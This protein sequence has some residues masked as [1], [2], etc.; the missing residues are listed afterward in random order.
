MYQIKNITMTNE[1]IV[2]EYLQRV[3][4]NTKWENK[5][6]AVGGC[7]RDE[8]MKIKPKDLDFVVLGDLNA[9]IEFATWLGE[10]LHIY[11]NDSNPVIYPRYGTAKLS[12]S[13]SKL[14]DIEL[15]FVAPRIEKYIENS[16]NPI[17]VKGELIDDIMRR[18]FCINSLAKNISTNEILDLSGNG[19]NDIKNC[20]IRTTS[21]P[22]IIFKDDPLRMMRAIR[23]TAKY[24]FSMLPEVV[25]SI[26]EH[27]ELINIIS[28]ERISDELSKILI[29][30]NP[31]LG[32][33]LLRKTNLLVHILG[34]EF[35]QLIGMTQNKFHVD[36]VYN[37]TLKVLSQTPPKL[38]VRLMALLHDV[39]KSE[40]RTV[41]DSVVHFYKHE[42]IGKDIA[43]NILVNLKY[44]NNI[45]D[46]VLKGIES[47]M[48]LK[49]GLD[50]S[51]KIND[52][53]L[54]KFKINMGD[55]LMDILDL[56][57]ADN[58]SH[59]IEHNMP[60]QIN[61][62]K[63]RIDNLK[64][65]SNKSDIILPINGHDL[66]TL[67]LK[68]GPIFRTIMDSVQDKWYENPDLTKEDAMSIVNDVLNNI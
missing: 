26:K 21:D 67:G 15:E 48:L 6:Y 5:I 19:I 2:L 55:D 27:S 3:I 60:N 14:P 43:R 33:E 37:H 36:D 63:E 65:P 53:A 30:P 38:N 51:Q 16:R 9:G 13:N 58:N 68:P 57:N 20:I 35:M 12:L 39:G 11:K 49:Y 61:I 59:A 34:S 7:V 42:L 40:T 1:E 50:D 25:E 54:R 8:I 29:S 22:K 18:D 32:I 56:I 64:M 47:H 4:K 10:A 62:L 52:K 17:V 45:I 24:N 66:I 28:K 44:S 41:E 31:V 46:S 23:F